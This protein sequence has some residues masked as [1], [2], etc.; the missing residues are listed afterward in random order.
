MPRLGFAS[1]PCSHTAAARESVPTRSFPGSFWGA[2]QQEI[3]VLQRRSC[4]L[5][6]IEADPMIEGPSG[7]LMHCLQYVVGRDLGVAI[8]PRRGVQ[9]LWGSRANRGPVPD[10]RL[11]QFPVAKRGWWALGDDLAPD[12]HRDPVGEELDRKSTR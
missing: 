6:L 9:P 4:H 1:R 12:D 5:Q 2:G 11:G 3:H 10:S 7:E 8:R